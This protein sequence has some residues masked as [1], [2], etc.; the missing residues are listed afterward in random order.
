M[1]NVWILN[2]YA[3]EPGGV[4]GT[5]HF[6]LADKLPSYGWQATIIAASI[7]YNSG[8]QRLASG[9]LRR[10]EIKS[11]VS[12]LWIRTPTYEGNGFGRMLNMLLYTIRVLLPGYIKGLPT[13]DVI[14]GSS[15]HPLAALAGSSL[16][17]RYRVPFIFEVRDLWPQ[18]LI[19]MGH[20]KEGSFVTWTL[21]RLE[22]WLY[23]RASRIVVLLPRAVDYIVPLGIP[24]ERVVW[25]P[26]GVDLS[27][28]PDP[29]PRQRNEDDPFVLMYFG[30]HGQANGLDNLLYAM[31]LVSDSVSPGMIK[32]RMVGDGP[33]KPDLIRLAEELALSNIS[34]EPPVPKKMIPSLA[35]AADAFVIPVPDIPR[36]YRYGI[37]PNKLF[38]YLAAARPIVIALNA[39]YNPVEESGGGITVPPDNPEALAQAIL[40]VSRMSEDDRYRMG[41][42]GR[43]YVAENHCY[44]HLVRRLAATLDACVDKR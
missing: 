43:C 18:T 17:R 3:L 8:R 39:A 37:S 4:G 2:H 19:D 9:E 38:D 13:P 21:R 22:Q 16:A 27:G 33:L 34:F 10:L 40:E 32:L 1:K 11:G 28:Y 36:L 35:S 23:R 26:N 6:Q 25:I 24:A 29:R 5:R 7:E 31:K 20:I 41:C 14:I 44:N 42:A 30:A 12:F 15:V